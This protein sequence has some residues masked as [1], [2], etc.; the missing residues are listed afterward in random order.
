MLADEMQNTIP[1][2]LAARSID[3]VDD[4][5]AIETLTAGDEQLGGDQLLGSKNLHRGA[6]LFSGNTTVDPALVNDERRVTHA[7]DQVDEVFSAVRL[8]KPHGVVHF[9]LE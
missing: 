6:E 5:G 2:D 4:V 8:G 7:G 1:I 9:R 3:D